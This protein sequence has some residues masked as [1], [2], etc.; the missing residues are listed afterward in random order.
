FPKG[1][2]ITN[3]I[4]DTFSPFYSDMNEFGSGAVAFDSTFDTDGVS[5]D[6]AALTVTA[7]LLITGTPGANDQYTIDLRKITNPAVPSNPATGGGYTVGVKVVRAGAAIATKTTMP[8]FIMPGGSRSITVNIYAGSQ[9]SPVSGATGDIFLRGGGPS[10]PMDKNVT[11]T[12]G[13]ITAVDGTSASSIQYA[14]LNDGC[15]YV[16]TEPLVTLG[17]VDYFGQMSPEP[18]CVDSV[19]TSRTKNIVLTSSAGAGSM[20]LTVKLSGIANFNGADL[21]IFAGGPNQFVVKNLTALGAPDAAGYTLRIPANGNWFVGV[22]PG[23]PKG[24]MMSKSSTVKQLP[25]VPPRPLN[26]IVS[27]VGGTPAIRTGF[28]V[29]PG[30]TVD[31]TN[32]VITFSFTSADKAITGQVTDGTTGLANVQVFMHSQGFGAP[33]FTKTDASGNFT[34]NVSEYGRYEIGAYADGIPPLNQ[35]IEVNPDG[36]DAGTDIDIFYKGKQ[37]VA[38]TNPLVLKLN[39][40]A[41]TIS[42]KILDDSSNG[43]ANAPVFAKDTDGNFV[44]GSTDSS[45]NYSVF[46]GAGTWTVGSELPPSK[47]EL[48]GTLSKTV[49]VTTASVPNQNIS[50]STGTCVTV[51]GTVTAGGVAMAN[52]P[53]FVSEWDTTNSRPVAGGVMRGTGTNS[54]GAYT[55]KLI[56]NKTYRIGTFDPDKG[57]LSITQAVVAS[58]ITSA[59]ITAGTL[60]NITFAFTGGTSSMNAFVE[61]KKATDKNI[62]LGKQKNGLDTSLT[63]SVQSGSYEYFVNV[64]GVGNFNGTTTAGSTVTIDLSTSSLFTLSGNVKDAD[65]A[66]ANNLKGALITAKDSAGFITTALTDAS[67]N[68]SLKAKSGTYTVSVSLASYTSGEAAKTVALTADTSAY[69]FGG[70]SPDQKAPT[71]AANVIK[72]TIYASDGTTKMTEGFVTGTSATGQVVSAAIDPQ[73]GTYSLPVNSGTWTINAKG[74]RHAETAK[75]GTVAVTTSDSLSNN[76]TL[77]ADATRVPKTDSATISSDVGGSLDSTAQSGIKVVAGPGVLETGSASVKLEVEKNYS[78]PDT[79]NF[80]P[81]GDAS[82]DITA[83]TT[84]TLKDLKG[85][86]DIQ[87]SYTDLLSTLPAGVSEADLK[88]AY[89]SPERDEYVPVEKGFTVDATANT[90]TA[91]TDHFTTFAIVYSPVVSAAAAAV[92]AAATSGGGIPTTGIAQKTAPKT[93]AQAETPTPKVTITKPIAQMTKA[94]LLAKIDEIKAAIQ[95]LIAQLA[96]LRGEVSVAYA[97]VPK[98]FAFGKVFKMGARADEVKHLQTILKAEVAEA[99]GEGTPISGYFGPLTKAA[100]IAF[101]E[102]Y[103]SEVLAPFGLTKGTGNLGAKTM[104]KLNALLQGK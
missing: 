100:L 57:E 1:T 26:I 70:A 62:R 23:M 60:Q 8:Y 27:G 14:S 77:T 36:S 43:I 31:T 78:A 54:S 30:V 44:G 33:A 38:V 48:C 3:A 83:K 41:Y 59:D 42:G 71:K 98:G 32:K 19:N 18:V 88:L 104:A 69:D 20:A 52:V 99:Y 90:I 67:G 75:T 61:V 74:P 79:E 91:Q 82:F 68:Y 56:G 25:G 49:T 97:G 45:G 22:G 29:P 55:V 89:Y 84:S 34:L 72:G 47:T 51:S 76:I 40:A 28:D 87:I 64:F 66:N 93:I 96:A 15:Y 103:A 80:Q 7:Q 11:L 17:G 13:I 73:D 101:Q 12:N 95:T 16:G 5:V 9:S 102:K 86:A 10:G 50:P 81:L 4:P 2:T 65:N 53:L 24:S 63:M 39:K 35:S 21:D 46:V 92:A 85:N 6:T 94:E 37:V 58:D